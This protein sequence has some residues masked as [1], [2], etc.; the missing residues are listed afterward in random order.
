MT[1]SRLLVLGTLI[2]IGEAIFGLPFHIPRYFRATT[3][4]VFSLSNTQLGDL[5]AV[6]G[7][8]ATLAYFPA[9]RWPTDFPRDG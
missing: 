5:F 9:A 7:V 3:L 8:T 1:P 6:Y 4:E 2:V